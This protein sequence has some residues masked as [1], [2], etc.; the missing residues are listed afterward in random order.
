MTDKRLGAKEVTVDQDFNE[1]LFVEIK[2]NNTDRLLVGIFYR[3]D[4]GTV[5]NNEILIITLNKITEMQYSHV[6]IMGDFNLPRIN[7]E[8]PHFGNYGTLELKFLDC[9]QNN[10]LFQFIDKPTR[11]RGSDTPSILYLIFSNDMNI[12]DLEY[13]SPLG[14]SD[15]IV[16]IFKYHCYAELVDKDTV[17]LLYD[18]TDYEGLNKEIKELDWK[19]ILLDDEKDINESW[20]K[21]HEKLSELE[22]KYVPKIK[23]RQ[24]KKH[25]MFPLDETV[26]TLVKKKHIMSRNMMKNNTD[27]TRR[28]YNEIRNK[29]KMPWKN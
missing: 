13:E 19:S 16:L 21:F 9:I 24:N 20:T 6:L 25:N 4:S 27:E 15:H 23:I 22:H 2:L 17:K 26:K 10:Y 28:A 3:S 1:N 5:E 8:L 11:C 14:K 18:K 7:W 29:V 12:S